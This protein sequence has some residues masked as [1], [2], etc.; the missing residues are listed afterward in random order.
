MKNFKMFCDKGVNEL[1]EIDE[2][3]IGLFFSINNE[4]VDSCCEDCIGDI[5]IESYKMLKRN[6]DKYGYDSRFDKLEIDLKY[7]W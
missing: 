1:G 5:L 7:K 2:E 6:C 3:M 4:I